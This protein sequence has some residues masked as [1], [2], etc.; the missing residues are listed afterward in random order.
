MRTTISLIALCSVLALAGCGGSDPND[1]PATTKIAEPHIVVPKGPPPTKLVIKDIEKG[2]GPAVRPGDEVTVKWVGFL[3]RKR[4]KF[5]SSWNDRNTFTFKTNA[6]RVIPG[7]DRGMY[8][9]RAGGTREL[10]IP[11]PLA[12]E[13]KGTTS[14]PPNET[15]IYVIDLLAI[16]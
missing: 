2:A 1:S 13:D 12:Y 7:W 3:Y 9:M 4:R 14:V 10:F 16:R 5:F 8:G 15:L 11:P 6:G